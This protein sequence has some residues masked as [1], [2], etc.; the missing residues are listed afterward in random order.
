M[1]PQGKRK[2]LKYSRSQGT[3]SLR[4]LPQDKA[5]AGR[6]SAPDSHS[7]RPRNATALPMAQSSR[8]A[9]DFPSLRR[10][11]GKSFWKGGARGGRTFF[12]KGFPPRKLFRQN[13]KIPGW[14][15]GR[16]K[17]GHHGAPQGKEY[18]KRPPRAESSKGVFEQSLAAAYF[19]T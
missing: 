15:R 6:L 9:A 8:H 16:S 19:P 13:K 2:T 12:Q 5:P 3:C 7:F 11:T 4:Y 1:D 17:A 14:Y 10:L 18:K